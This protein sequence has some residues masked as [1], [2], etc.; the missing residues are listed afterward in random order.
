MTKTV[1]S[2]RILILAQKQSHLSQ[3]QNRN[4][5][6]RSASLTVGEYIARMLLSWEAEL[7][8]SR[9][10]QLSCRAEQ[11]ATPQFHIVCDKFTASTTNCQW[12]LGLEDLL[13]INE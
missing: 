13:D 6:I 2:G 3:C 8:H 5:I 4:N 7:A 1:G 11:I 9:T 10:T 12:H